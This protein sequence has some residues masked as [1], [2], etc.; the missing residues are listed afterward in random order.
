MRQAKEIGKAGQ[1]FMWRTLSM[2][3]VYDYVFHLLNEYAKLQTFNPVVPPEA[4]IVCQNTILCFADDKKSKNILS[5]SEEKASILPPC[6][7]APH[8]ELFIKDIEL[9][10]QKK[11]KIRHGWY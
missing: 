7:F 4:Q 5:K 1:D 2:N 8:S 9:Q 3:H 11:N 10:M 6:T